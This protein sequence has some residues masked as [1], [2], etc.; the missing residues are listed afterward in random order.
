MKEE[1]NNKTIAEL[2]ST[3]EIHENTLRQWEKLF[4][5]P[6][7]RAKDSQ[8]SRYYTSIEVNIFTKIR[9]LRRE[10]MSIDNIR[11]VLGRNLEFIEQNETAIQNLPISEISTSDI[12]N[13]IAG[14]IVER[15]MQL[16]EEFKKEIK[17][18]LEKQEI[19]IFE[20]ITQ[21]Q[22]EQVQTENEK[23]LK[24][25]IELRDKDKK[26]LFGWFKK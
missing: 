15:E 14:I 21:K 22:L 24:Y 18:E 10:R 8:R 5:I 6:V 12:Q 3:L 23:L 2:S 7:P 11:R 25:I 17:E 20:S 9:N 1:E 4:E 16:K 26:G 19:R 13:L